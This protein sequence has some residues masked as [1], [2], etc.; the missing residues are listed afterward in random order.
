MQLKTRAPGYWLVHNV[1]PSIGLQFPLAPWV[2]FLTKKPEQYSGEKKA[3]ST[4]GAS[5]TGYLPVEESK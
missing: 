1:V 2:R 5:L 3:S 4:N